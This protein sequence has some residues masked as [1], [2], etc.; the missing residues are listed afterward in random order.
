MYFDWRLWAFTKGAR[1]RIAA[2]VALGIACAAVGIARLALL[3]WLLAAVFRGRPLDDLVL[4]VA[5]VGL[6]ML[7]RGALEHWRTMVAHETA[8]RIQRKLR[9]TIF[10]KIV[11]LGPQHFG[12]RRTGDVIV[13]LVDGVEQLETYFGQYLPQLFVAAL[14]PL[15]IAGFAWFL[16]H[17]IAAVLLAAAL[18]TLVAPSTFHGWDQKNSLARSTAYKAFA[19]DFL[20]SLQ[21]LA[22]LKAFGQSGARL[23]L[24]SERAHALFRSTMWVLATNALAR[25]ITDAGIAIGAAVALGVGAWRVTTGEASLEVLL[26]VLMMGTE[27]FR[28]LRDLRALLHNGM[29]GQSA[30]ISIFNILDQSP[31]IHDKPLDARPPLAPT[32]AF[33]DVVF[34]YPGSDEPA[35]KGVSFRVDA[36][37]RIGV[38]GASGSGKSTLLKLLLRLHD[39]D[40]GTVRVGGV[41]ARE[42]DFKSL[43]AQMAVVSQDTHMFHGTVAENLAFGR[44][45]ATPDEM[46]A[47]AEMANAHGFISALPQGYDTVIGERGVKLSGGQRQRIAIARALLRDAP[48]LI[49]D[50]ALSAVDAENEWIIQEALG[51][52][53]QGRTTLIFAHRLSSVIDCGRI[54]VMQEGQVADSGSHAELIQRPGPYRELMAVQAAEGTSRVELSARDVI[55][56]ESPSEDAADRAAVAAGPAEGIIVASDLTWSQVIG[57]LMAHV[58]PWRDKLWMTLGCGVMRVFAFIGVGVAGALAVAAVKQGQPYLPYLYALAVLA[59]VAGLFHWFESWIA[60]DMAFR[61]LTEMRIQLFRK[62]DALAPAFLVR[63]R[64]GDLVAMATQD[65]EMVEYFF[66][67]TLAPAVVAVLVP[68]TVLVLLAASHPLL[69]AALLPFLLFVGLSPFLMRGRIDRL[70]ARTREALGELNAHAVDTVQGLTEIAAF[71]REGDRGREFDDKVQAY[72][73]IRVPFFRD[74]SVQHAALE[75]A[76]G[77]GGLAVVVA[78][79]SLV[80]GGTIAPELLPMMTILAMAAFLPVS[81]IAHVGRQLA[82]TMGATRRLHVVDSEP[83]TV[84]DGPGVAEDTSGR[85]RGLEL[86]HVSFAYPGRAEPALDGVTLDIP[87]GTTLA[88]VG[89]S[90]AGK[91]TLANLMLRFWDPA[92]GAIRLGG[93]DLRDYRLDALRGQFAL[94]A[95][96]TYLFNDTLR[97]NVMLA[98]PEAT[99]QELDLAIERAAL[100]DFIRRLPAGLETPVGERG[101]RLS[102]GQRQRV[103]I[104]R[105]FLK[106]APVLVLDEATSHLDS[107]SENAV[108]AALAALMRDRTTVI[109]AHRLSTVRDADVIAVF[110]KGRLIETGSH[111]DLL[112]RGGLYA[113]LVQRQL[114]GMAAE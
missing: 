22:T 55:L 80:A 103:A 29:I 114:A 52:L 16:D 70:G 17:Y 97:A 24:L 51:R 26:I 41:D 54:L 14:T 90:G 62:I 46:R 9:R 2:T 94:V 58:G 69:A 6:T 19:A 86:A 109:I 108:R 67:H 105:A 93:A 7:A 92:S 101:V 20:D 63:R 85:S 23:D 76:T 57:A 60:H 39:P 78:G 82:D 33:E 100:G 4:P 3:G 40:S 71:Q 106:D 102:G 47:A 95:Q 64:S 21:G 111:R 99:P 1:G 43:R 110:D 5:L 35:H 98:R 49:L 112:A 84:V 38:V 88:L 81:E 91:T 113:H 59:P 15:L 77:L 61:M 37:E 96:D 83:I 73:R 89:P 31:V 12:Q 28:P 44:P 104:A 30:A 13:S 68:G 66:A 65:V 11:E 50:E 74:L 79:A 107:L 45:G 56:G 87:A 8:A 75:A 48:I 18:L 27:A 25:G 10:D 32:L 42:L 36:G 53:M 34:T 72:L